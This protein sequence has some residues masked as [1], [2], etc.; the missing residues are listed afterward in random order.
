MALMFMSNLSSSASIFFSS[1]HS[2]HCMMREMRCCLARS[3]PW[4]SKGSV[5]GTP[6]RRVAPYGRVSFLE[7]L[8]IRHPSVKII[9]KPSNLST[10]LYTAISSFLYLAIHYLPLSISFSPSTTHDTRF[11]AFSSYTLWVPSQS[12]YNLYRSL[13]CFLYTSLYPLLRFKNT[14]PSRLSTSTRHEL[15]KSPKPS[16]PTFGEPPDILHYC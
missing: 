7:G 8:C 14:Y 5:F 12:I 13:H 3:V 11:S 2:K 4:F 10:A 1:R 16:H 9:P 6:Q 15:I